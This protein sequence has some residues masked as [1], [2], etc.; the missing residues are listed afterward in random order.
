MKKLIAFMMAAVLALGCVSGLA[1]TTKHERVY[2]VAAA[3]GA[4]KSLIDTVRLENGGGLETLADQTRLTAVQNVGGKE[5]FRQNGESLV[6]QADGKD[7]VYQ[8][9]SDQSPAILPVVTLTLDGREITAEA[10]KTQ[11]GEAVLTVAYPA[12]EAL[13]ALAVTVLPLPETGVSDLKLENA[14]VLTEM[15][16][17][18]LVGWAVPGVDE[19]L[20]LPASFTASFHADHANLSWMMTLTTSDP[21]DMACRELD[22]RIGLDLRAELNG[23]QALLTALENGEALPE[24]DSKIGEIA[25][26]INELNSGLT[27]LNDGAAALADGTSQLH[28]GSSALTDGAAQVDAG[29]LALVQGLSQ[30]SSGAAQLNDGLTALTANNEALNSGAAALF[31]AVLNTANQQLS[32]SGLAESGIVLPELT[33]ENYAEALD[34]A[35]SQLNPE[36]LRASAYTQVEAAVRAQVEAKKDQ[37]REA[38]RAVA[39]SKVLEGVLQA[40][41]NPMTAEQYEQAV[42]EGKFTQLQ[43]TVISGTVKAKMET[44][45]IKAQVEAAVAEQIEKLVKENTESYLATDE[46]VAAKLAAGQTAY[47]S[48]TGLKGQLAQVE[49]FVTGVKAYTDGA[50]QAAAG[51][52]AL[53]EGAAQAAA[54]AETL[55]SGTAQLKDGAASL[56]DGAVQLKDG[57]AALWAEGTQKLRDTLLNA[58]K[59][60]A[61]T[62][63]PYVTK[64]LSNALGMY[65]NLRENV[66]NA[67]YDLRPEGMRAVTVYII[68]TDLQ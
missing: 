59:S 61:E 37:V 38:V 48:L 57:A 53:N 1:E 58:E 31:D 11:T 5:S 3:D 45:E 2:V 9:T 27:Q 50:A 52:A 49:A 44:D 12:A 62:L 67:G 41:G 64:D 60:A 7:I 14:A 20:G 4:V 47:E 56:R 36:A 13:P 22:S 18:V 42:K 43:T 8:G 19:A 26:K 24:A 35:I 29:A 10:L 39:E 55:Q 21:I 28:G 54:G 30:L 63:M 68:R 25:G 65:E 23:V 6:W 33:K 34:A 51:A 66:R 46:T 17:Q 15:G 32:A 40:T 16:K